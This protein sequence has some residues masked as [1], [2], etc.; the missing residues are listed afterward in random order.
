MSLLE[1]VRDTLVLLRGCR[2]S[3]FNLVLEILDEENLNIH[4]IEQN[5]TK[6]GTKNYT[7]SLMQ[8]F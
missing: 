1:C 4:V 8:L 3:P 7:K 2:L 6:K 5:S